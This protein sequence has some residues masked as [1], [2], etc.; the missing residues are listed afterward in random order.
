MS[1]SS[2]TSVIWDV[3]HDRNGDFVGRDE[4]LGDLNRRFAKGDRVQVLHGMGGIGKT[5]AAME[6]AFRYRNDYTLVWWVP[7][8]SE[9]SVLL[10]YEKL[11]TRLGE[12]LSPRATPAVAVELL[13][14]LLASHRYLLIYDGATDGRAIL[15]LLPSMPGGHVLITSRQA[16]WGGAVNGQ[17]MR[18]LAREESV[19]FLRRRS[20]AR[21]P[22][23]VEQV[24]QTL[25]DLPLAMEQAA[26]VMKQSGMSF[27]D[28]LRRFE[29]Q[30]ASMLGEGLR[31]VD[32]PR[33]FAMTWSLSVSEVERASPAA[34]ELL[35]LASFLNSDHVSLKFLRDGAPFLSPGLYGVATDMRLWISAMSA[36]MNYSLVEVDQG[37]AF[38]MH[39]LAAAVTRDRLP[40]AQ[41]GTWCLSAIELLAGT[42]KFDSA[43][44]ATWGPCGELL[45]HVLETTAHAERLDVGTKGAVALSNDAGRYL[46]RRAQYAEA[47]D[48]LRRA[49]HMC[50]RQLDSHDPKRSSIANNLG[51]ALD[52]LGESD[53]AIMLYSQA[54][55]ID[56]AAYGDT[57]PHVA[58]VVNNYGIALQRKG[59]HATARQQFEWAAQI[60]EHHHGPLHPKLA[61]ILNNLGHALKSANDPA[62]AQVHLRRALQIAEGTVGP[63]HP[64]TAQILSNLADVTAR[65]GQLNEARE[66]MGRALSINETALGPTHPNVAS[67]CEALAAILT[68]LGQPNLAVGFSDRAAQIRQG[69]ASG[70]QSR[71]RASPALQP[72]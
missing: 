11:A 52:H 62:G 4:L 1:E 33:S 13:N 55:A 17:P 35:S 20:G 9:S 24:A 56:T 31:P 59:H 53:Q 64:T 6:Y 37:R 16:E 46:L 22:E 30:W 2:D 65:G 48:V 51:R 69:V 19:N 61:P 10:A 50:D 27:T 40:D 43:D 47:R 15:P 68:R 32:Y 36:L 23:G 3:P 41:Q 5:Q 60:Y 7:A 67:D 44:V 39:R 21:D 57:H 63:H 28:Y 45:P 71:G 25:G 18:V 29:T 66:L 72:G 26:A 70:S 12:R 42:F 34:A 58:E 14:G 38:G 8:L 54:I 49:I